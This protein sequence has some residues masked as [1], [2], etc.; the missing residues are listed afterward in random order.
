M[1]ILLHL[2]IGSCKGLSMYSVLFY[3]HIKLYPLDS[4][5]TKIYELF[6]RERRRRESGVKVDLFG[7]RCSVHQSPEESHIGVFCCLVLQ[8]IQKN[9]SC[10]LSE[11]IL[12][13]CPKYN[14][15]KTAYLFLVVWSWMSVMF[16]HAAI[17][18]LKISDAGKSRSVW[19]ISVENRALYYPVMA[20]QTLYICDTALHMQVIPE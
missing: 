6:H 9:V 10:W 14:Q 5:L 8:K 3:S 2:R 17:H 20:L 19:K 16:A 13:S 15:Q 1:F 4:R 11:L 18:S 12:F 7:N